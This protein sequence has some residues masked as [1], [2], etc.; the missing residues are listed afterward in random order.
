MNSIKINLSI[1]SHQQS[2]IIKDILDELSNNN[3]IFNKIIITINAKENF[4]SLKEFKH[5]PIHFIVNEIPKGFGEN[6]NYAYKLHECDYFAVIN[7][8]VKL[9]KINFLNLIKYFEFRDVHIVAPTAVDEK[10]NIQDNARRFPSVLS[11]IIRKL[12]IYNKNYYVDSEKYTYVDWLSGMFMIIKSSVFEKIKGFDENY[13]MYYEDV[14]IC[15]RIK[16]NGGKVMRINTEKIF[17]V[18]Q[19]NS[20]KKVK[21]FLIHIKSMFY[22]HLK[23]IFK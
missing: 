1:I 18:G 23:Y 13:F 19:R 16:M 5:L 20:H 17:H 3:N 8:D 9:K 6:H 14:D 21:Y 7:P 4:E 10:N 15:R 12:G 2:H 11:P 22:Y